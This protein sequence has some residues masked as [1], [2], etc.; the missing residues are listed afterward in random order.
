MQ[1]PILIAI[2]CLKVGGTEIQ[3]LYLTKALISSGYKCVVACYFEYDYSM[4]QQFEEAGCT[5]ICISAYGK[6]PEGTMAS[7]RFLYDGLRRIVNEYKPV[8]AHVQYMAPGA[9]P[10]I[11]LRMLGVGKIVATLHTD[12]SIYKSLNLIRL[13]QRHVVT[14]FTC[15]TKVAEQ[16]FFS[17]ST[18]YDN[19]YQLKRRNH[20]TIHNCL[21]SGFVFNTTRQFGAQHPITIGAVARLETIKGA[22]FIIPAFAKIL[23]HFPDTKLIIV[24]DGK[25]RS[26]MEHQQSECDIP[27]ENITWEGRASHNKL[28]DLYRQMDIVWVPSRSEGFGLSAI[29]AMAQGCAVVA[30]RTGG[31]TEVIDDEIDGL[32]FKP[33]DIDELAA[34]TVLLISNPD[35]TERLQINAINKAKLFTFENYKQ[36]IASLYSKL[37]Q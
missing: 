33:E 15:V 5:V 34:K 35:T 23:K 29:E 2:P 31:L 8:V 1:R 13:L 9:M 18:L 25:L 21:S 26:L 36:Q 32:L 16:S 3:T 30:S 10:I 17:S 28:P 6:R 12:A 37:I 20:I 27:K 24:G 19:S 22:D 11:I 14:V 4:V 7:F